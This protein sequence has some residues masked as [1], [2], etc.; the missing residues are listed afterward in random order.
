VAVPRCGGCRGGAFLCRDG[1]AAAPVASPASTGPGAVLATARGASVALALIVTASAFT[2]ADS[3]TGNFAA[4]FVWVIWWVGLA[5]VQALVGD[6]WS[7]VNP[8]RTLARGLDTALR[9][10]RDR[11]R[12][13]RCGPRGPSAAGLGYWPAALGFLAFAWLEL[14]SDLGEHPQTLGVMIVAYTVAT[15][16]AAA[17]FGDA[18]FERGDPFS[19]VFTVL[20]RFA[21]LRVDP[22]GGPPG[23][24]LPG[25]G[26]LAD[27]PV[28]PS[29]TVLVV[30][31]LATVSF[32]GFL[33]TPPWAA[34][35]EWVTV[36]ETLRAPLLALQ[37]AGVNLL[38]LVETAGLIAAI[39]LF[40]LVY[41]LFAWLV[42]RCSG[43]PRGLGD[44]SGRYVLTL[45]PIAI[46]YHLAHYLSYLLIAGQLIETA[47]LLAAVVLFVLVYL[48]FAW[49]VDRC[50]GAP[51]GLGDS[52][53]RY[54]LTL[55]PIAIGYHLAHYLSYLLIAGQ[56][57][58]PLASDPFDLGWDLLGTRGYQIDIAIVD[59]RFVWY[60]AVFTVIA[61]H[62]IA[63]W[64]AHATALA[65]YGD[66]RRAIL[67][68][69]PML[70]LMV[71]YT[72]TSLWILSQPIVAV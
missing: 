61:G 65:V 44:S 38:Q 15:L 47:G 37:G 27:T 21:P 63:V 24:R 53:G 11:R 60:A 20:G 26:L 39:V 2:G 55:V 8:W 50:S 12:P 68:Q 52:S 72:M 43:A 35:L 69:I 51:R 56:L 70:V 30:A 9:G 40:V 14:V 13:V 67:S 7:Q 48:L 42:D 59:A 58:I 22:A 28:P 32:D 5:F 4:V 25:R 6:V 23:L 33:E 41:L 64:L 34:L 29:M 57:I 66:R 46:G 17:A 1:A 45:V 3:P 31:L 18:W 62:V 49:L 71:G 54:V 36:S 19:V 10:I 16:A